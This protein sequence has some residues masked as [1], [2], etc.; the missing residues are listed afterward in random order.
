MTNKDKLEKLAAD[1]LHVA[2]ANAYDAY[3]KAIA[4]AYHDA[5]AD[6]YDTYVA[7]NA[8]AVDAYNKEVNND[9]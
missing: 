5:I 3:V 8:A 9:K 2:I 6:A 1:K 7:A 4:D